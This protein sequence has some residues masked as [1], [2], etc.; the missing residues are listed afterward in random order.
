MNN[1]QQC[2]RIVTSQ[3]EHKAVL[4]PCKKLEQEEYEVIYLPVDPEGRVRLEEAEEAINSQ[5]FLVSIQAANNEIGTL[6]PITEIAKLAHQHGALIHT[7]AAQVVGKIPV[8]VDDLGVDLL[9]MSAHKFYGP[10]GIGALYIRGGSKEHTFR[11][12]SLW[13]R[14]R[15]WFAVWDEQCAC[16]RWIW[17]SM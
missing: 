5:T 3:I 15:K 11:A 10:K 7:D 8:D 6:Q 14:T 4:L 2:R 13:G 1:Q 12:V 16:D 17:R 9:S